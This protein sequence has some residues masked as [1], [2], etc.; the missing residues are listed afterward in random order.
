MDAR[1]WKFQ[2]NKK[3][4]L[5]SSKRTSKVMNKIIIVGHPRSGYREIESLLINTG[6]SSALPT[7]REGLTAQALNSQL[8][9]AHGAPTLDELTS[10]HVDD[11]KQLSIS[12]IWYSLV[13][14]LIRSNM[15]QS[16]W[17]WADPMAL[18][19]LDFWKSV[20]PD[21]TFLLV[22]NHPRTALT[23]VGD[24]AN[25]VIDEAGV[26]SPGQEIQNWRY[27]NE[28]LLRFYHTNKEQCLLVHAKQLQETPED[29]LLEMNPLQNT[30][31]DL[32]R[33]KLF[34]EDVEQRED[35]IF[36]K[37]DSEAP[38]PISLSLFMQE[39]ALAQSC[40][41]DYHRGSPLQSYLVKALLNHYPEALKLYDA[42]QNEASIASHVKDNTDVGINIAWHEFQEI[43]AANGRLISNN[44]SIQKQLQRS[45][46]ELDKLN[47]TFSQKLL[48]IKS[49]EQNLEQTQASAASRN[50][51][52]LAAQ[53]FTNHLS[54]QIE[55]KELQIAGMEKEARSKQR[56]L[57]QETDVILR[58]LHLAQEE[59]EK[60]IG[61]NRYKELQLSEAKKQLSGMKTQLREQKRQLQTS[62]SQHRKEIERLEACQKPVFMG[63]KE[64]QRNEL[65]YL[66]GY[67]LVGLSRS[68]AK[69]KLLFYPIFIRKFL[70]EYL[71][72]CDTT[73]K[74]MPPLQEY[75]DYEEAIKAQNHL[76]YL[77]G[78]AWQ[79]NRRRFGAYLITPFAL[80]S[81][82]RLWKKQK[83]KKKK[84]AEI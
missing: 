44:T 14:D 5:V 18:F 84:L 52:L 59:L 67:T 40:E 11:W 62:L 6:M 78:L 33:K 77:L 39:R 3:S 32:A 48:Q 47:K 17:G 20:S 36:N 13:L 42:L 26:I 70:E 71:L 1:L 29:L 82:Y 4:N 58:Q 66:V 9:E 41:D 51:E 81:T 61:E 19:L 37:K 10:G 50:K 12:P 2:E 73:D 74:W 16:L 65:V 25:L 31:M 28:E 63:A 57:M 15:K 46:V 49:L 60:L 21:I 24:Q 22:Y 38:E 34:V 75:R 54:R 30:Q 7:L 23:S 69:W 79:K 72:D 27:Y 64:R 56:N 83:V 80:F 35:V 55:N 76:S 53:S 45:R 43:L 8:C 68:F